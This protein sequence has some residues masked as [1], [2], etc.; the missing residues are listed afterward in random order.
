MFIGSLAEQ[1]YADTENFAKF[2]DVDER[3]LAK[4]WV[5]GRELGGKDMRV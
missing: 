4:S 2:V 1:M 5:K 3:D